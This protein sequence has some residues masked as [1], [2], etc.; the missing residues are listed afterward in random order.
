MP[1]AATS[2]PATPRTTTSS[3]RLALLLF[4][5]VGAAL[6]AYRLGADSL[7]Y[8][9]TVSL[10]LAGKPVAAL[11]AHTARDIH[12]P[13]YYLLLRAWTLLAGR[14]ELAAAWLSYAAGLLLMPATYALVRRVTG[15]QEIALGTVGLMAISPY[16]VWYAQEVRMYTLGALLAVLGGRAAWCLLEETLR[17]GGAISS[18][19]WWTLAVTSALGLYTLYYYAF[20]LATLAGLVFGVLALEAWRRGHAAWLRTALRPWLRA[21]GLTLLLWLPWVPVAY[22]Q[23]TDP[24]VPPWRQWT[25]LAEL[26][27]ESFAAL[28]FGQSVRPEAISGW[29]AV[30]LLLYGLGLLRLATHPR[31]RHPARVTIFLAAWTWG[32]L[33]LIV[34]FSLLLQPLYHVR[35]VFTY[36]PPFY[37]VMAAGGLA[38]LEV[39]RRAQ[40]TARARVPLYPAV[41]LLVALF[42]ASTSARS[43]RRFWHDP[44]YR[45]DDF[46][47]GMARLEANWHPGDALLINAGYVYPAF[48]YY[49]RGPV[50]WQ[51]RLV[52]YP[53][54]T[55]ESRGL[56]VLQTG[57][58]E[59][60]PSLGWGRPDSD[61][62]LT[63]EAETAAALD[64]VAR[65]HPRLWV[66]RAYDTVTDPEG[67]IRRWLE[68]RGL[69]FYDELLTGPSNVRLQGWLMPA[70]FGGE[71][72]MGITAQFL[73]PERGVP[74]VRLEG[75]AQPPARLRGGEVLYLTLYVQPLPDLTGPVRLSAGLFDATGRQWT[76]ADRAPLGPL[77]ALADVGGRGPVAVPVRLPLPP[78]LPPGNYEVR[79]KFYRPSDGRPLPVAAETAVGPDQV[80]TVLVEVL[81]TSAAVPMPAVGRPLNDMAGPL[82]LRGATL[83]ERAFKPGEV[84]EVELLWQT[85]GPVPPGIEPVLVAEGA[86]EDQDR[87]TARLPSGR[88]PA[89]AWLRDVHRLLVRP[90]AAPGRYPLAVRLLRDGRT[91]VWSGLLRTKEAVEV[92]T[93]EV[94]D[95]P[96]LFTP[97][98]VGNRVG[99][100]FGDAIELVGFDVDRRHVAPGEALRV[101]LVW[102]AL[103]RPAERYKVFTHLVGPD[104]QIHGQRDLEPGDGLLPTNGWAPGEYVVMEYEVPLAATAPAGT[105]E[106][107]LGLYEPQTGKRVPVDHPQANAQEHYLSLAAVEVS[108]AP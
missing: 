36:S 77:L 38:L 29:L 4:I 7:W 76:V 23:A 21:A 101:R 33:A 20:W 48:N 107:R 68:T 13:F 104:G 95:R 17:R 75:L 82:R 16:H 1:R 59:G 64:A 65:R 9:E 94:V 28:A 18:S 67:F 86:V 3:A 93:L 89:D 80:R 10:L 6:R 69:L 79:L 34:L 14:S 106:L 47:G 63:D 54:V 91:L 100:L 99:A 2:R 108:G 25:P 43:L 90:D 49:F 26:A 11:V 55:V 60:T 35:Y 56:V 19:A 85:T 103:D 98:A 66:L 22:R 12:P 5:L 8:D 62:Y 83:P 92:G 57:S 74:L 37:A 72:A 97:P 39:A 46:K 58:L 15:R 52:N 88:W 71:P 84:L 24:P 96:R 105:Y 50:A 32:P 78:G 42:W 30:A 81:P 87:L 61:F 44:L 40:R 53:G 51:G 31:V 102:R 41:L 73:D 45:A 27:R 70:A